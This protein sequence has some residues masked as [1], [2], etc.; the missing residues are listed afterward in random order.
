MC[1]VLD[2]GY[3]FHR[4]SSA[5]DISNTIRLVILWIWGFIATCFKR[6]ACIPECLGYWGDKGRKLIS[7]VKRELYFSHNTFPDF[8][9]YQLRDFFFSIYQLSLTWASMVF[10]CDH[11]TFY[12]P[13][14][15]VAGSF[16]HLL[17]PAWTNT[18]F[19]CFQTGFAWCLN[20]QLCVLW[21]DE[22]LQFLLHWQEPTIDCVNQIDRVAEGIDSSPRY[23]ILQIK[24]CNF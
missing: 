13:Q 22:C 4:Y 17:L 15:P 10:P 7:S 5:E 12:F 21:C 1:L 8:N 19:C 18:Y 23:I 2:T 6:N 16:T 14:Q 11:I 9:P 24:S 20:L 3:S